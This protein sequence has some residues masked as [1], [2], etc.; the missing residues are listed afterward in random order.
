[1][2]HNKNQWIKIHSICFFISNAIYFPD[3]HYLN[4]FRSLNKFL[5]RINV[6]IQ[7]QSFKL[8]QRNS[9]SFN[10][11]LSNS[12]FDK[13]KKKRKMNRVH[14][15]TKPE[16][17]V[18]RPSQNWRKLLM[19]KSIEIEQNEQA[20]MDPP[21]TPSSPPPKFKVLEYNQCLMARLGIHSFRLTEPT[22]DF[23]KSF[24]TYVNIFLAFVLFVF[25]NAWYIYRIP[26]Q[27]QAKI[28]AFLLIVAGIQYGGMFISIGF[29]MKKTKILHLK[30]QEIVDEGISIFV[31]YFQV[32][33][34]RK[35]N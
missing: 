24:A 17:S 11:R 15:D 18:F 35:L 1:M 22:N 13:R 31:I 28:E 10:R 33:C 25:S 30:L 19:A 26:T 4:P 29:N 34:F 5:K 9:L 8:L 6:S 2:F 16:A 14:K 12:K 20:A 32:F 7:H 27:F 3:I 21:P 23:F